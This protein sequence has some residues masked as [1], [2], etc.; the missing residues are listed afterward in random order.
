VVDLGFKGASAAGGRLLVSA[1]G[2]KGEN[3]FQKALKSG[4]LET[5]KNITLRVCSVKII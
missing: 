3:D 5:G 2:W 1:E 4:I